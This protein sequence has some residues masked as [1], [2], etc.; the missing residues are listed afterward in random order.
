MVGC[1]DEALHQPR[2]VP[3]TGLEIPTQRAQRAPQQVRG[4]VVT[5][6][7]GANEKPTQAHHPM[8]VGTVSAVTQ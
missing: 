3:E 6:H 8:Q 1:L 4:E 5:V 7:R 2:T